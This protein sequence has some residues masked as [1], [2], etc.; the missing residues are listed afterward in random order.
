MS[1][2]RTAHAHS[3]I[4]WTAERN[5]KP[6]D[7]RWFVD[8]ARWFVNQPPLNKS[9][10][11]GN[12]AALAFYYVQSNYGITPQV[13]DAWL[14][15]KWNYMND[16]LF[17]LFFYSRICRSLYC[18]FQRLT[19]YRLYKRVLKTGLHLQ[20]LHYTSTIIS[21]F[22]LYIDSAKVKPLRKTSVNTYRRCCLLANSTAELNKG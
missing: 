14:T 11:C 7:A 22:T 4:D 16:I 2:S 19:M 12:F 18:E 9:C 6:P 17:N 1:W 15:L 21:G 5:I 10:L 13:L 3:T 8:S 20:C